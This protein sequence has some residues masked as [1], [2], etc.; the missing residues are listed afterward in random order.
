MHTKRASVQRPYLCVELLLMNYICRNSV[1]RR[2][3]NYNKWESVKAVI[4]GLGRLNLKH[5]IMPRKINFSHSCIVTYQ[6]LHVAMLDVF[7]HFCYA[8]EMKS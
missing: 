7:G 8:M 2:I 5:L 3:F 4:L 6:I 1:F